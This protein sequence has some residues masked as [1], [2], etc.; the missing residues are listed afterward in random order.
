MLLFVC[1]LQAYYIDNKQAASNE[2]ERP[3]WSDWR[4]CWRSRQQ[5]PSLGTAAYLA[6]LAAARTCPS[7][8]HWLCTLSRDACTAVC[9]Y[10]NRLCDK[11]H[12]PHRISSFS[13]GDF[14]NLQRLCLMGMLVFIPPCA[15]EQNL[16]GGMMQFFTG[17]NTFLSS[18]CV[19]ALK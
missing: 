17:R 11:Q 15:L 3:V 16:L 7:W 14:Q 12:H 19:R 5:Q 9:Q 2:K 13:Y 1:C 10:E 8:N 6:R 18:N 4:A